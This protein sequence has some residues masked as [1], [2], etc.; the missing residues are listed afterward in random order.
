MEINFDAIDAGFTRYLYSVVHCNAD[1]TPSSILPMEYMTGFQGLEI[2][3]FANSLATTTAYTNYRF[4]LP[5][6][7]V[8]FKLS[9]NYV[10]KVYPE[11]KPDKVAFT[12]CFFVTESVVSIDTKVS[13]NTDIDV[14]KN[15][16]QLEFAINH[17]NFPIPHPL[18]DM[19]LYVYQNDRRDNVV[20]G[21]KPSSILQ[22]QLVYSH[23]S[24]L[25]FKGGNEYRRM[26]FL[27]NKYNGMNVQDIQ[28]HNPYY[29]VTL[30]PEQKRN[31][32][33]YQYDQD[34]NGRFFIRCSGCDEPDIEADYHIV[35]FT[36]DEAEIPGGNVFLNGQFLYND[37]NEDSR[38]EYN[39]ETRKYEKSLLLK[40]GSYNY[41]YLFVPG[42]ETA[43]QTL[44]V[45]GDFAETENEYT[46][47]VYYRPIGA[48]YDR[49]I[50]FTKISN[51]MSVF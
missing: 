46:I 37:F 28:F 36:L 38:M 7:D 34:Q 24:E 23:L 14:N 30:Y 31:A 39:S 35:H 6:N 47:A 13:G 8:N 40:E 26:E 11:D 43:G 44:P 16:Q 50:G 42:G 1:W 45:E 9:G 20:T 3:D 21:M 17:K 5:N 2:E 41:Q 12:A 25:I 29:H 22:D 10:V 51:K 19:K 48:R 18:M 4:F 27:S 15:H 49:I 33:S 32:G